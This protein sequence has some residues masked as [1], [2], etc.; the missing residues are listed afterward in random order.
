MRTIQI[1]GIFSSL[2]LIGCGGGSSSSNG[3]STS[4]NEATSTQPSTTDSNSSESTNDEG[5]S[6]QTATTTPATKTDALDENTTSTANTEDNT[7]TPNTTTTDTIT[8]TIT[9][10]IVDTNQAKCYNSSGTEVSCSGSGQDGAYSRNMPSYTNNND[11]TI[12]DNQTTLIWQ[13]SPDTNGDGTIDANDKLSQSNAVSY[14][15]SLT[16]GGKSDWRLPDIKTLYSLMDFS[17]EDPSGYEGTDTSTLIPFIDTSMFAFGYGDTDSG[18]RVIDA[19][20]ATTTIYV[21]TVMNG[22]EAMFGLNLADGRIKGYPTS[23]KSYYVQ[24]VRNAENYAQNNF[25]D[26]NDETIS[27]SATNLMWQKSDNGSS[28]NWESAINYCEN[29][30]LA[31]KNDWRLPNVKELH[32]IVD[33]T[34]SPDTSS[35]AAINALFSTTSITNEKGVSDYGFYW[36]ST[37]HKN[38]NNGASGAYISFGRA[39]GY[40]TNAWLDVHGAGAQRSDPKDISNLNTS[41]PA[42]NTVDGAITHGPQGD[43]IRG[44]NFARCVRDIN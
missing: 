42:Y 39:L 4:E 24:C 14:C 44:L 29:L 31:S 3:L 36:S 26:N 15:E 33:Y 19:Q 12:T 34:R 13:Q 30:S 6:T 20:W 40:M 11:G 35:S 16:L 22:S 8:S 7:S 2:M 10:P 43:V 21:Y 32:S 18:E 1:I 5:T 23:N 41:D 27:D 17:G 25:V 37:T 38:M 28:V 9:Y